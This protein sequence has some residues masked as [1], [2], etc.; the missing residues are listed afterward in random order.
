MNKEGLVSL[1]GYLA[2][3]LLGL[4]TGQHVLRGLEKRHVEHVRTSETEQEHAK[5][6]SEKRRTEL[7]LELFGYAVG[8][9][10]LL[11]SW[12]VLGG[13]VSRRMVSRCDGLGAD[14]QANLPYILWIAAYNTTFLLG[15]LIIELALFSTPTPRHAV[16]L[17]LDAI[18]QNGLVV[19]IVA[20]L[21]TGL[22][23]VSME[24]MYVGEGMAMGVLVGYSVV[25]CGLAWV[26]RGVR[27]KL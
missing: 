25:V 22:V 4:A 11:G 19:F 13:E 17:L 15:Y 24:T 16:P 5:T 2:I 1:P 18:N 6:R 26:I 3:Y 20:N 10:V 23:N 27:L 21:M 12:R 7:A 14:H 8:W 9:W